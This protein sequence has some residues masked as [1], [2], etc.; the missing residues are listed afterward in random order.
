MTT[1]PRRKLPRLLV[2]LNSQLVVDSEAPCSAQSVD[3]VR[4]VCK[5]GRES[6]RDPVSPGVLTLTVSVSNVADVHRWADATVAAALV[7]P[8]LITDHPEW[9]GVWSVEEVA[10]NPT[11]VGERSELTITG[12]DLIGVL[13]RTP[14]TGSDPPRLAGTLAGPS[15]AWAAHLDRASRLDV[16]TLAPIGTVAVHR[17]FG[18][19]PP[20][21]G[22]LPDHYEHG[23][24]C[25]EL[26]VVA[27]QTLYRPAGMAVGVAVIDL[28]QIVAGSMEWTRSSAGN[29]DT[30]TA[31]SP[32]GDIRLST[33]DASSG[34]AE[35]T[36]DVGTYL[37][38]GAA[39]AVASEALAASGGGSSWD[40]AG[41]VVDLAINYGIL[42]QLISLEA[43]WSIA[44]LTGRL[45]LVS[46]TLHNGSARTVDHIA[47]D[48]TATEHRITLA[49]GDPLPIAGPIRF[50]SAPGL[51]IDSANAVPEGA[52]FGEPPG[53]GWEHLD[54]TFLEVRQLGVDL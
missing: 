41:A 37:T 12:T 5:S 52:T 30:V 6:W 44:H 34:H 46:P 16:H 3:L 39:V 4:L 13:A 49:L 42:H 29:I 43:P 28:C 8:G 26:A 7:A 48:R 10:W 14:A 38:W 45:D 36:W 25:V 21:S 24:R 9:L 18:F 22:D 32:S 19:D 15:W 23:W 11:A 40:L 31:S 35:S 1:L 53:S 20:L 27:G 51:T 50:N 17:K 33:W 54:K 2:W 47:H